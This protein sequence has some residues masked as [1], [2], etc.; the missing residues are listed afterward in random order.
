MFAE[1]TIHAHT[2]SQGNINAATA[3]EKKKDALS[4]ARGV[5]LGMI[6]GG[7]LWA[8]LFAGCPLLWHPL[9]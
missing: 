6:M 2:F 4:T 1:I 9:H 7:A 3:D 5:L 8:L